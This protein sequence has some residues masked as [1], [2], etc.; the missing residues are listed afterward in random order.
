MRSGSNDDPQ[1][2]PGVASLVGE[3]LDKGTAHRNAT[4]IADSFGQQGTQFGV[5]VGKTYTLISVA[6][7]SRTASTTVK[8]FL[9]IIKEPAFSEAELRRT[10]SQALAGVRQLVDEP[11]R[12][13]GEVFDS[14]TYPGMPTGQPT[15]GTLLS[16]KQIQRKHI[17]KYYLANYRPNNSLL[18]VVGQYPPDIEAQ[19]EQLTK[20]W[21]AK[22]VRTAMPDDMPITPGVALRLITKP[23]LKQAEVIF[24]QP[25][26]RRADPQ[27]LTLRLANTILGSSFSSRL[28]AEIRVH[29]ALT[30]HIDS[31]FDARLGRGPFLIETA[32][33]FEKVHDIIVETLKVLKEFREKGV[34]DVEVERA[35][36]F[37][38]GNFPRALETPERLADNLL[39]LKYY[40]IDDDY[41]THFFQHVDAITTGQINEAIKKYFD[42]GNI[43]VQVYAPRSVEAQ[44]KSIGPV[45]VKSIQE[46]M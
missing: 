38:K 13:A 15:P 18:A 32:T 9:E 43:R 12:F 14:Y 8:E 10:R 5:S 45:E 17:I 4:E 41:L 11:N 24:G 39:L 25:G 7:L 2:L 36:S 22:D 19:I 6:G 44:L 29:Q 33:R 21:V 46:F 31:T 28:A 16:I 30:Y 23:D 42:P 20:D 26:I 34:T 27:Y 40:A 3:L 35:R 1:G 37:L